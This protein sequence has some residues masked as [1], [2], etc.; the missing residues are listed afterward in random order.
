[1]SDRVE[2][3]YTHQVQLISSSRFDFTFTARA[4]TYIEVAPSSSWFNKDMIAR[5]PSYFNR[6]ELPLLP[7]GLNFYF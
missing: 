2:I 4:V 3:S 6:N 5:Y 1:M 7:K